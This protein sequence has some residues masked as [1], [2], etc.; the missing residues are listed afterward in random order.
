[1]P[2]YGCF[3]FW[4]VGMCRYMYVYACM[5]MYVYVSVAIAC[6]GTETTTASPKHPLVTQHQ[7]GPTQGTPGHVPNHFLTPSQYHTSTRFWDF[8][9]K[10]GV[11][12]CIATAVESVTS[13]GTGQNIAHWPTH[14]H[15]TGPTHECR[16][17]I[18]IYGLLVHETCTPYNNF[19]FCGVLPRP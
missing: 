19:V 17:Q 11:W 12:T 10:I 8:C 15:C 9:S 5:C 4:I 1:M 6:W 14:E 2:R 16:N 13:I 7:G 3:K 18:C